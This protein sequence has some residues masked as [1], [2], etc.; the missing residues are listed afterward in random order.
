MCIRD[1]DYVLDCVV[2][3]LMI[4]LMIVFVTRNKVSISWRAGK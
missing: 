4:G 3:F 2:A 1:S